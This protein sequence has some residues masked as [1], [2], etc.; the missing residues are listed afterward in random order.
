[1]I[2]N[3]TKEEVKR[4]GIGIV[5]AVYSAKMRSAPNSPFPYVSISAGASLCS[6]VPE[7]NLDDYLAEADKELYLAKNG[8]RNRFYFLGKEIK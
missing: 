4:I 3:A 1:V 5:K 6:M 7:K 8:G 2:P